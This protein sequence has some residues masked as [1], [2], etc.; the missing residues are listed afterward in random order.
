LVLAMVLGEGLLTLQGYQSGDAQPVPLGAVLRAAAP[1]LAVLLA[2]GL[3]MAFFGFRAWR[4]GQ[5]DGLT[6]AGTGVA[7]TI[8]LIALNV[9]GL[10][11][12]R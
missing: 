5:R 3:A 12:G 1:A 8:G 10:V 4:R 6:L 2:P 9:A 7:V 11:V